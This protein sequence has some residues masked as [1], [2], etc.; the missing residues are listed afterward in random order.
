MTMEQ[1]QEQEQRLRVG[2]VGTGHWA[3]EAHIP[4]FLACPGVEVAAICSRGGERGEQVARRFAIPRVYKSA[5]EMVAA[6]N[7]DLVSIVTPDDCHA[8]EAGAAIAAG[9]NVLCE[10]PLARTYAE[11]RAMTEAAMTAGVLTKVGFT[12]R[13]APAV[14]RLQELVAEGFIGTP[15]LLQMFL[16]NGQFLSPEK[17]RHW[18]MIREHAGAGAVVE[19]G[20]HGLD[21]A[22]W[23]LGDV[24]RVSAAGRTFIPERPL[25]DGAATVPIDVD[26]S[27]VW[28]M[29][30][31]NGALAVAHAGWATIGRAPGLDLRVFGSEGA[32]QCILADDLPS[33]ESLR[34][35]TADDQRFV[36]TTI[37]A[38]LATPLPMN[39][40]WWRR[41]HGN[42]IR[43]FV[44]EL[45]AGE[46]R[47]PTFDDG[48]RA[49]AL[50][51]GLL[52]SMAERRW[53]AL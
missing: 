9:L 15:Y 23:L 12:M 29:E 42:L 3:A 46:A 7:L 38:R 20:I 40:P 44:D 32:V 34:V 10:K 16:Q 18:K 33:S 2:I 30:F 24:A 19:Y 47:E 8:A 43:H 48:A 21:L 45:R 31:A 17:P 1:E 52:V 22:R 37:P 35:A 13:Y 27:T 25:A 6:G 26:D 39:E 4:G 49:Q 36:P 41:F 11:A 50:L 51:E 28:L 14:M 5:E 53:V